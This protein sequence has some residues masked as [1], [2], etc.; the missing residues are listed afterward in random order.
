[1]VQ[2]GSA[3]RASRSLL[4]GEEAGRFVAYERSISQRSFLRKTAALYRAVGGSQGCLSP[5]SNS[6]DWPSLG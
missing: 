6:R 3:F 2:C 5:A 1:M 4:P